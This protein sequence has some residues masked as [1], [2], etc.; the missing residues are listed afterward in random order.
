MPSTDDRYKILE[1]KTAQIATTGDLRLELVASLTDGWSG[2]DI[3]LLLKDASLIAAGA[4]RR[5]V[6]HEDLVLAVERLASRPRVGK[7]A[8]NRE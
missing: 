1:L 2:A 6:S 5:S 3:D 8:E 4:R 7:K